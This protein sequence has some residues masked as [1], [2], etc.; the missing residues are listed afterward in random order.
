MFFFLDKATNYST[1]FEIINKKYKR[2]M[3]VVRGVKK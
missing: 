2:T 3:Y 1:K